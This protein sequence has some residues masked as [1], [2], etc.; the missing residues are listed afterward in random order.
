MT[1]SITPRS[2]RRAAAA[3]DTSR[4]SKAGALA[5]VLPL[6]SLGLLLLV[7]PD[8]PPVEKHP[9]ADIALA[10]LDLVCPAAVAPGDSVLAAQQETDGEITVRVGKAEPDT[11]RVDV[12]AAKV[13]SSRQPVVV[14][15][16][17]QVAPGLVAARVGPRGATQC[18]SPRAEAWFTGLGARPTHRSSIRLT[19]PDAGPA[20][21]DFEVFSRRGPLNVAALRGIRVPGRSTL[22]LDLAE[23]SPRRTDLAAKLTVQRGRIGS[24]VWDEGDP[25]GRGAVPGGWLAPQAEPG[26]ALRLLGVPRFDRGTQTLTLLNPGDSEA[27]A[28]LRFIG[29]E[30]EFAPEGLDDVTIAPGSV[31]SVALHDLVAAEQG[32]IL[33]VLVESTLPVTATLRA[34]TEDRLTHA[35]PGAEL[36]D[37]AGVIPAG[38]A[39]IV[40]AGATKAGT[41]VLS[42]D[43]GDDVRARVGPRRGTTLEIPAGAST[44]RVRF[45]GT[46]ARAALVVRTRTGMISTPLAPLVLQG[47]APYVGPALPGADQPE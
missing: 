43:T 12:S 9:P 42:T 21:A 40:I 18:A 32:D 31:V 13:S 14:T 27:R 39:A 45:T 28:T 3:R 33:G 16:V 17:D 46:T 8:A 7:N 29:A 25:F 19:N 22:T 30:S 24:S 35:T 47:Q 36:S 34:E 11:V 5:L 23:V 1:D 4:V 26:T 6:I 15:G 2:G 44:F 37:A 38:Q 20:I 41:V 10:R